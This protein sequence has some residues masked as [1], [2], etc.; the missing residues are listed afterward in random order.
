M[1][2][3]APGPY[4]CSLWLRLLLEGMS[5]TRTEGFFGETRYDPE[6]VKA[7]QA[8]ADFTTWF[9]QYVQTSWKEKYHRHSG[10][11]SPQQWRHLPEEPRE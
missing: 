6:T 9:S 3:D 1:V 7:K 8:S 5:S 11:G 10:Q 2:P 4:K